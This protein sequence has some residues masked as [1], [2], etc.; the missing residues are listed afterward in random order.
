MYLISSCLTG[1]NC[2]YNGSNNYHKIANELI[3]KGLAIKA[4][5][6]V[7]GGLPT[8]RIPSEIVD[9]RVLNKIGHDHTNAFTVGAQKTLKLIQKHH[10]EIAI[11]QE[12]S[13]SCGVHHIYDGT[14]SN[15]LIDGQGKTAALLRSHGVKVITIDDYMREY[16][17]YDFKE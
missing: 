12:R 4:C 15:R 1:E 13:P 2:K 10:I 14:F 3:E 17:Q 6:E 16:Y 11:L 9:D 5:P 8:P 7:L